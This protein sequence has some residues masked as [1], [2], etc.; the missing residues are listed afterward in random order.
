[1][2]LNGND[3]IGVRARGRRHRSAGAVSAITCGLGL[4]VLAG[5]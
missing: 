1:M 5:R 3:G 2:N 4:A